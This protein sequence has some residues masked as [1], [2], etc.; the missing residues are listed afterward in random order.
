MK[1]P[2]NNTGAQKWEYYPTRNGVTQMFGPK[3]HIFDVSVQFNIDNPNN[4]FYLFIYE[5]TWLNFTYFFEY[6]Y[7]VT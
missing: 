2:E 6:M 3:I 1:I 4:L 7:I 5:K